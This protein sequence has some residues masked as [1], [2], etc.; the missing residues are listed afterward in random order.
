[1][2]HSFT[3][4]LYLEKETLNATDFCHATFLGSLH[5]DMLHDTCNMCGRINPPTSTLIEF[6]VLLEVFD[7]NNVVGFTKEPD[8]SQ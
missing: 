8:K 5:G 1:M 4:K 6:F 3:R 7:Q 2:Q